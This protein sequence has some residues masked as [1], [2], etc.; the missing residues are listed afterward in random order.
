MPPQLEFDAGLLAQDVV[1]A[2]GTVMQGGKGKALSADFESLFEKACAYR[3]AKRIADNHREYERLTKE[4]AEQEQ[5][6]KKEFLKAYLPVA[7]MAMEWCAER[8]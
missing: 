1:D 7:N 4:E 2:W 8:V 5:V 6:T 3:I